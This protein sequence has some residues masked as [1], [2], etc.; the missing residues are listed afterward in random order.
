MTFYRGPKLLNS[1]FLPPKSLLLGGG[2]GSGAGDEDYWLLGSLLLFGSNWD[3]RFGIFI[4]C[5]SMVHFA[6]RS[7][8]FCYVQ[9]FGDSYNL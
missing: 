6:Q 4:L 9:P 3:D 8:L 7:T 2:G 5:P 1:Q